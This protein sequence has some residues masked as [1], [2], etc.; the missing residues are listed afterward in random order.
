MLVAL[1]KIQ[2]FVFSWTSLIS[3]Y[4]RIK[5]QF[6]VISL[7]LLNLSFIIRPTNANGEVNKEAA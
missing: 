4:Q 3:I 2:T 5:C 6:H 7:L 1:S